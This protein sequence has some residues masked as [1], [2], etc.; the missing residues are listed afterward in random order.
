VRLPIELRKIEGAPPSFIDLLFAEVL[1]AS[2]KG[3]FA[4][5]KQDNLTGRWK[6]SILRT[7]G[8]S[9][10]MKAEVDEELAWKMSVVAEGQNLELSKVVGEVVWARSLEFT[11]PL[12]EYKP[13]KIEKFA[14]AYIQKRNQ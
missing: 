14:K 4:K 11:Y 8:V 7:G 6:V 9:E 5:N 3:L 13:D 12:S 10:Y 2:G 1:P